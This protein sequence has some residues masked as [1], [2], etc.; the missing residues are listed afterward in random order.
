MH[1]MD[2]LI[3]TLENDGW[4]RA[5]ADYRFTKSIPTGGTFGRATASLVMDESGRWLESIDGWNHVIRSI[6]LRNYLNDPRGAIEA[7]VA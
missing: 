1:I 5:G 6:D 7:A 4:D 2:Q 3:E